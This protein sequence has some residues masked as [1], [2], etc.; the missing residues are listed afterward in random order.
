MGYKI[1][2]ACLKQQK[3]ALLTKKKDYL[4]WSTVIVS[5]HFCNEIETPQCWKERVQDQKYGQVFCFGFKSFA[6][7]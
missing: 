7:F 4:S 3:L 5:D 6:S 2:A 1:K